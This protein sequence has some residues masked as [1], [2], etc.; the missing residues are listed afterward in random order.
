MH[1]AIAFAIVDHLEPKDALIVHPSKF[2]ANVVQ[3][4]H[5]IPFR[6]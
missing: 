4:S 5:T 2:L 6:S 1:Q 3:G